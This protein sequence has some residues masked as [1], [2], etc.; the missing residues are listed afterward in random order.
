MV[1]PRFLLVNGSPVPYEIAAQ[2]YLITRRAKQTVSSAY[3]GQDAAPL[4]HRH[5]KHTQ[6]EI[7]RMYP[8]ISNPPGRSSH[9]CR[10]DGVVGK[11]YAYLKSWQCGIDSGTNSDRDKAATVAAA[12][13]YGWKVYHP[14]NRGV[15]GHHWNF[16]RNPL[17][18]NAAQ[19][20]QLILIRKR[21]PRK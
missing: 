20:A 14:Y 8:G 17:G 18:R 6:A 2:V 13:H 3:R 1:R 9:E 7:H 16:L 15:E 21:L 10:G 5:G 11:L 19:R 12:Q 4:L